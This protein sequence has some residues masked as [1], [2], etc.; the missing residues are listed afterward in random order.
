MSLTRSTSSP[1]ILARSITRCEGVAARL[2]PLPLREKEQETATKP[3]FAPQQDLPG[4]IRQSLDELRT[5][6]AG[7]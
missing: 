2:D 4:L 1:D 6:T 3:R 5:V 7:R